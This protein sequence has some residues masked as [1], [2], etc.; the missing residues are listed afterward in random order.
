MDSSGT[1]WDR[2]RCP[3]PYKVLEEVPI[4]SF[5][6]IIL[7]SYSFERGQKSEDRLMVSVG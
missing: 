1:L 5:L 4:N 2:S 3:I 6:D 7:V